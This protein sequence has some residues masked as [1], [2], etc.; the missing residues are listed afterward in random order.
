ML[1]QGIVQLLAAWAL[2]VGAQRRG[3]LRSVAA[4]RFQADQRAVLF[5]GGAGVLSARI[6]ALPS[7]WCGSVSFPRWRRSPW[8]TRTGL[9][10]VAGALAHH[11]LGEQGQGASF[12]AS[13]SACSARCCAT[14]VARRRLH[15]RASAA[16]SRGWP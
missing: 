11:A 8:H 12:G 13:W 4:Q 3:E 5:G 16:L 7:S 9:P 2:A 15:A 1:A 6:A 14:G 10:P